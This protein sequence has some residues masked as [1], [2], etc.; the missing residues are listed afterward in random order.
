MGVDSRRHSNTFPGAA[1]LH[2][3]ESLRA[4]VAHAEGPSQEKAFS[5]YWNVSQIMELGM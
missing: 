3:W 1:P 4:R 5:D 2:G